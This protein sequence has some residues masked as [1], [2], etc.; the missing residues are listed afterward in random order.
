VSYSP[1]LARSFQ[2]SIPGAIPAQDTLILPILPT[3][4]KYYLASVRWIC[5]TAGGDV[6]HPSIALGT[7]SGGSEIMTVVT[8][9]GTPLDGAISASVNP[10]ITVS[11]IPLIDRVYARTD[12]ISAAYL[13]RLWGL[14]YVI[15]NA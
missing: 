4:L 12:A 10:Y 6:S 3:G 9:A 11:Q 7:T 8:P 15:P 2:I 14:Y 1:N 13:G 5:D